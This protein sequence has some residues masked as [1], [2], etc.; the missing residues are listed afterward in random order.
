MR[1]H[2]Y[3]LLM[4]GALPAPD[5]AD[6]AYCTE[7]SSRIAGLSYLATI[8]SNKRCAAPNSVR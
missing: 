5:E 8:I 1:L 2:G 3:T 7:I 4:V 6:R